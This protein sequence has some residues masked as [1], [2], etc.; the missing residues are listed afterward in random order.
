MG[1]PHGSVDDLNFK[2]N[3]LSIMNYNYQ[4]DG[5]HK[6]GVRKFIYSDIDCLQLVESS[7]IESNGS[8]FHKYFAYFE[9]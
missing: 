7:L 2:P 8:G 5:V 6:N 9:I 4:F 3:H 1:L